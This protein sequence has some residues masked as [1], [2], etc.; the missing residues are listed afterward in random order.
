[1]DDTKRYRDEALPITAE[2]G[3][4]G[5][6]FADPTYQQ[7]EA[8][9]PGQDGLRRSDDTSQPNAAS[10]VAH[11]ANHRGE[12]AEGSVGADPGPAEGMKKYPTEK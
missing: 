4:E 12:I 3:G 10:E 6:S 1:M 9:P 8:T 5:G 7:T 11:N 2:V